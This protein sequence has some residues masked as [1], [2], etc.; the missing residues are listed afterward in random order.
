LISGRGNT[1][2]KKRWKQNTSF[3]KLH[4]Q[5]SQVN[6]SKLLLEKGFLEESE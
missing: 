3:E 4:K 2:Q 1:E 6:F 5:I